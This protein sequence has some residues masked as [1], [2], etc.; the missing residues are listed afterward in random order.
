MAKA[1]EGAPLK[2]ETF[3]GL[4]RESREKALD[5]LEAPL[6]RGELRGRRES[7]ERAKLGRGELSPL[8]LCCRAKSGDAQGREGGHGRERQDRRRERPP[9]WEARGAEPQRRPRREALLRRAE[10]EAFAREGELSPASLKE[11]RSKERGEEGESGSGREEE[12]RSS[13]EARE[14]RRGEKRPRACQRRSARAWQRAREKRR[15]SR[16]SE[17]IASHGREARAS[18]ASETGGKE[19]EA[20]KEEESM[21]KTA[22]R[23]RSLAS[24]P[25]YRGRRRRRGARA[26][27]ETIRHNAAMRIGA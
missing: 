15:A 4:A 18:S 8:L 19:R 9:L 5:C 14:R 13:E 10:R 20:L 25:Y 12:S 2:E 6:E 16:A 21:A 24:E 17:A 7:E 23:R 11:E 3:G 22:K 26:R 27:I 1:K